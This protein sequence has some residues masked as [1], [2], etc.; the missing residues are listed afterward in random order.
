[1]NDNSIETLVGLAAENAAPIVQAAMPLAILLL[2]AVTVV[3]VIK[4]LAPALIITAAL[5]GWIVAMRGPQGLEE[6]CVA[7]KSSLGAVLNNPAVLLESLRLWL[8]AIF[9]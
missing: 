5:V 9:S 4:A 8:E 6:V 2:V 3:R 1:M 7:M